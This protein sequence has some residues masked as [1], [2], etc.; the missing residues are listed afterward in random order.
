[1]MSV[2]LTPAPVSGDTLVLG[3]TLPDGTRL[4]ASG[5]VRWASAVLPG[6]IGVE[7][8]VPMPPALRR[9]IEELLASLPGVPA[10]AA[11]Q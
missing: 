3:F 4:D 8:D 5:R 9:H 2:E 10:R 6:M 1:M 7:F 11:G